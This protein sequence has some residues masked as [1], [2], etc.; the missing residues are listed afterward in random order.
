L[1]GQKHRDRIRRR[2]CHLVRPALGPFYKASDCF[3]P[4]WRWLGD[5]E[6][7]AGPARH[8]FLSQH[9]EYAGHEPVAEIHACGVQR[10]ACLRRAKI[11]KI[12]R[13]AQGKAILRDR[14]LC[15]A[16]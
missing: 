8:V 11:N 3:V 2:A 7:V 6:Q 14:S 13:I 12:T 9:P 4:R 1:L 15:E 16:G 5:T 10:I